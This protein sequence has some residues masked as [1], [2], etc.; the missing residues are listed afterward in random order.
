MRYLIFI[1]ANT[2]NPASEK[3]KLRAWYELQIK[4]HQFRKYSSEYE[5]N[6]KLVGY[7]NTI[8]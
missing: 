1:N 4:K 3:S 5:Q 6:R 7:L 2:N 8:F